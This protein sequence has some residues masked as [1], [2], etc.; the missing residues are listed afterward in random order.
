[1]F[2]LVFILNKTPLV[3]PCTAHR[4]KSRFYFGGSYLLITYLGKISTLSN[5]QK[6]CLVWGGWSVHHVLANLARYMICII[7]FTI[8][9]IWFAYD[10]QWFGKLRIICEPYD[11]PLNI[12]LN[13]LIFAGITSTPQNLQIYQF[14]VSVRH[15]EVVCV[16]FHWRN[17]LL[18]WGF[19]ITV[20]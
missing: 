4:G 12:A 1:M 3:F 8:I 20:D 6:N 16:L 18:I 5:P 14:F 7:W 11:L 17:P 13:F 19:T 2:G 10:L 15:Y 9:P